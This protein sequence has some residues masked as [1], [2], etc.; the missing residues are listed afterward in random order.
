M[1][2][3][4]EHTKNNI[5]RRRNKK[6]KYFSR[7]FLG[8]LKFVFIFLIIIMCVGT[9]FVVGCIKGIIANAPNVNIDSILSMGYATTVY[10][11][12]GNITDNLVMAG[13]NRQEATYEE[14]P[15][16]LINAFVAIE[17]SRFWQ[18]NGIDAKSILRAFMGVIM[19]NSSSGGGSTITQQLIKNNVFD[20]GREKSFQAKLERKIQEQYLA[21]RLEKSMDKKIIIT[22]YLNTINLGNNSLGVKVAAKRYFGKELNEL[23][24]SECAVI[25]GITQ[26]PSRLNPISGAKANAEKR[27]VI[28]QYMLDQ[29]YITKEQKQE[30][31]DDNVYDRIKNINMQISGNNKVYSY[32]TDELIE[33]VTTDFIEKL[34]YTET[35]AKNL[36]F[37]GG[38]SIYTTQDPVLQGIVDEEINNEQNYPRTIL[39]VEYRLTVK[40]GDDK[41]LNFSEEDIKKYHEGILKDGHDGLYYSEEDAKKDVEAFKNYIL[42]KGTTFVA[43]SFKTIYEPQVSFVLMDNA[44]GEV[45]AVNGGRG[46]KEASRTLN[47]ATNVYRQPGSVFK[48]IASFAPALDAKGATLA[49]VYYDAPYSIGAKS[50]KNWYSGYTGWSNIREGIIYSMNIVAIRAFMETVT[51]PLAIEYIEDFGIT[52]LTSD[53]VGASV[54]LGGLSKGVSNL[55]TTAAFAAIANKGLYNKPSFYT[56]IVDHNGKILLENDDEAKRVIKES[57]AFLLTDAMSASLVSNRKFTSGNYNVTSTSTRARLNNMSAAGKSGTTTSNKDAWFVGYTPYYTAGIWTGYDENQRLN[58][59]IGESSTHKNIWKKIMD[60][61]HEGKEDPGFEKPANIVS[62]NVC[63]KSGKLPISGL[64]D[65]DPRGNAVY[66]EYFEAGTE[67]TEVCDHHAHVP[68]CVE[69]NMQAGP[70]CP[71][72]R[73]GVITIVPNGAG[74]TDDTN[75]S[76]SVVCS[77]HSGVDASLN[78]NNT[79]KV[80]APPGE[81]TVSSGPG[82]NLRSPGVE[83]VGPGN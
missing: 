23:T 83:V 75:F 10:D 3:S 16:D 82:A 68:I 76:K 32:F 40:D 49:T 30:A 51:P 33:Q 65:S 77:V 6:K 28:L 34:G 69:T 80:G 74:F 67:P 9:S 35:Q 57:T 70:N 73:E 71:N 61:V 25:A 37:S 19:K 4:S 50:F 22:N 47:R 18:H 38:L 44:T 43:E 64:C 72:V 8:I 36:L 26:N 78:P 1:N 27:K 39:S 2:Y 5:K 81:N 48:I 59:G 53:D 45:K 11:S 7:I 41:N 52:S 42:E 66:T 62:V 12:R 31:L 14:I 56:K 13:S 58:S 54:A 20:G 17:D 24:L 55:E 46:K 63:R 79:V 15:T 60:R 21:L 29:G